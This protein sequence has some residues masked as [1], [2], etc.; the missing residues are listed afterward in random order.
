MSSAATCRTY[1]ASYLASLPMAQR[2]VFLERLTPDQMRKLKRDWQFWAR[3]NQLLPGGEWDTWLIMAGR[4]WGKTRS[5]S[6]AVL[7]LVERG[8]RSIGLIARTV[9]DT[10]NVMIE[11]PMS[12]LEA[13]ARRRGYEVNYEPSKRK[14]TFPNGAVAYTYSGDNP[15]Q[16]RGPEHDALWAD[17]L[18]AWRYAEAWDMAQFGL[19]IGERPLAIVTTTPRPVPHLR[20]LLADPGT[21]V[22]RGSTYDNRANLSARALR[23]LEQQYGGTRLGRQELYAEILD[24]V[25]GALWTRTI[26]DEGRVRNVPELVRIVVA[27]DPAVTAGEN[28]DWTGIVVAG[29]GADRHGYVL[30]DLTVQTSPERWARIAVAAYERWKADRIIAESNNGGDMVATTLRTVDP[31]VPVRLVHAARGKRTRAEPVSAL[32]EQGRVHHVG[33]LPELEDQLC[34][35]VPGDE[36]PDRLDALVWALTD[37][38]LGSGGRAGVANG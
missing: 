1:S 24:D 22:T 9:G 29:I 15:D 11:G 34:T 19:R 5:G 30:D 4:G 26:L 7:D 33:A 6:E 17:E 27:I 16:L 31:L 37:L 20:E 3:D 2:R 14:V 32:Y 21:R 10:R 25:P 13:C 18:A 8:Y 28:S 12:G 35:W 23:K 36:S 38:M